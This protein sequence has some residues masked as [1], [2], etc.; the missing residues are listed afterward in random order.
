MKH[1]SAIR[2][3]MYQGRKRAFREQI[4]AIKKMATNDKAFEEICN[5]IAFM[6]R[7]EGWEIVESKLMA[8]ANPFNC[9]ED[10]RYN[11]SKLAAS[12][13]IL[14]LLGW[15]DGVVSHAKEANK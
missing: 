2:R 12:A 7:T 15:I 11:E 3:T 1:G 9:L 10:G 13:M 6:V 5:Q 8:M 14:K 4:Q